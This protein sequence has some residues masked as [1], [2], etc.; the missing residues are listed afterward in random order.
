MAASIATR[1]PRVADL[2]APVVLALLDLVPKGP[3]ALAV[4]QIRPAPADGRVVVEAA[5]HAVMAQIEVDGDCDRPIAIPRGPL[6]VLRKRAADAERLVLDAAPEPS[7][8]GLRAFSSDATVALSCP[9]AAALPALPMVELP[10][11][12]AVAAGDALPLL[13]DPALLG[14]AVA[15][16]RRLGASTVRLELLQ[17]PV[18]GAAVAIAA[19]PGSELTGSIQIA[20][21]LPQEAR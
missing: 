9:E 12:P 15:V 2:P 10:E 21:I 8:I 4:L 20:R 5:S 3:E 6:A 1:R 16:L 17:H 19:G 11:R 18:V 13:L 14:R 7:L